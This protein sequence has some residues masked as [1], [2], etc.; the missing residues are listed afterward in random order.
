[1]TP[2]SPRSV[3]RGRAWR[4]G[5]DVSTDLLAPGTY[6][7]D[8]LEARKLHTLESVDPRFAQ[9]V[10]P[11]DVVVAGRNFGC[12]SS[13]ETAPEGLLALGVGCVVAESFAR[14]FLRN[15]VA[16]GL[17]VL[18]CPGVLDAL[19]PGDVVAVDLAVGSVRNVNTGVEVRGEPLPE[20]MRRILAA[21]GILAVLRRRAGEDPSDLGVDSVPGSPAV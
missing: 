6:A 20:E 15:A 14:L 19:E 11:G 2:R 1:M 10:E 3:I 16:I 17:P 21:G 9:E 18:S 4:F 13:R 5:H 12:G 7:L 8:P